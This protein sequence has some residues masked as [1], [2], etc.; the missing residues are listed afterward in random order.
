MN[1]KSILSGELNTE[2]ESDE[3]YNTF[4]YFN[5]R[6]DKTMYFSSRA[7]V[8]EKT[9]TNDISILYGIIEDITASEEQKSELKRL[10]KELQQLSVLDT[11]TGLYNR[12]KSD[13]ILS[14]EMDRYKRTKQSFGIILLDIDFF[15]KVNDTYGHSVGDEVL[16]EIATLLKN[17]VRKMD[18]VFRWGGEEFLIF[19]PETNVDGTFHLAE[20]I[21][22]VVEQHIFHIANKLTISLGVAAIEEDD[23]LNMILKRADKY[24]YKAKNL[25]RNNVVYN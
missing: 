19:C 2:Q 8:L 3:Y 5:K 9:K 15:K 13:E 22:S 10:N 21:R 12:R 25:G 16:I 17:Y 11:L 14:Y 6:L 20:S 1:N 18:K 7:L 4:P 24:L 23:T